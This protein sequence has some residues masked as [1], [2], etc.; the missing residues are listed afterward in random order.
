MPSRVKR[1]SPGDLVTLNDGR[2]GATLATVT[3]AM[4]TDAD[5][6]RRLD[7]LSQKLRVPRSGLVSRAVSEF[8]DLQQSADHVAR[9]NRAGAPQGTAEERAFRLN[10]LRTIG[11]LRPH[12]TWG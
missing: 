1:K 11:I 8:L 9:M 12:Q 2:R 10:A 6:F 4:S 7:R 5:M 3:T